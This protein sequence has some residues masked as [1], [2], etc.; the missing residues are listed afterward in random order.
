VAQEAW[1]QVGDAAQHRRRQVIVRDGEACH[2][3]PLGR[4]IDHRHLARR[5]VL[6]AGEQILDL[7]QRPLGRASLGG[8]PVALGGEH[9]CGLRTPRSRWQ[10]C[11]GGWRHASSYPYRTAAVG[12][13][14][15]GDP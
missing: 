11:R 8:E 4:E 1:L 14:I 6:M 13:R 9:R 15:G 5:L 2:G 10:R 7:G 12:P 3:D